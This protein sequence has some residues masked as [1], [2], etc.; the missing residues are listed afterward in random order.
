MR[1]RIQY[2]KFGKARRKIWI[3]PVKETNMGV[4]PALFGLWQISRK[5][6]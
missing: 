5:T 6:N 1:L 3:N 4:A 2:E